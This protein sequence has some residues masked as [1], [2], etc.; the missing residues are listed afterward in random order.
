M[1]KDRSIKRNGPQLPNQ[2]EM[3]TSIL[4]NGEDSPKRERGPE[5]KH[6]LPREVP[7]KTPGGKIRHHCPMKG[8]S[9]DFHCLKKG[10]MIKCTDC[11][12][13]ISRFSGAKCLP[14]NAR[15]AGRRREEKD[16]RKA[17]ERIDAKLLKKGKMP[18]SKN[19]GL[20]KMLLAPHPSGIRKRTGR[21]GERAP[22]RCSPCSRDSALP[23]S[24]PQLSGEE[25]VDHDE[26]AEDEDEWE[27]IREDDNDQENTAD[28]T[29][30][31]RR[32]E[33]DAALQ[34]KIHESLLKLLS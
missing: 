1:A 7:G 33:E 30:Y 2:P 14:C 24:S 8:H 12:I 22:G 21:V 31:Q 10:C 28:E 34:R 15:E 18:A 19:G 3:D 4:H 6:G 27:D 26:M 25:F 29:R 11:G 16:A 5:N 17:Q 23:S 20:A 9:S 13:R 32:M